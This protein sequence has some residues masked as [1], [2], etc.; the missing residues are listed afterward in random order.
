MPFMKS[1]GAASL[2]ATLLIGAAP[3]AAQAPSA[4][5]AGAARA[6]NPALA[7]LRRVEQTYNGIR[8]M[9]ATFEQR[10][11]VPLLGSNQRS[12]GRLFLRKPDRFAMVFTDPAGDRIVADGRH[13][14][15]YQPSS[16]PKQV[17]RTSIARGQRQVDFQR[18]F[19]TDAA[20]RYVP[21]LA[22]REMVDGRA[23]QVLSLVP[24]GSSPYKLI[25]AWVD[26]QDSLVRRW[27]I[28]EENGSVRRLDLRNV[29]LNAALPD[30][31]FRFTAPKGAQ[32]FD[33]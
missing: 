26:T 33:Q 29:R 30:S 20:R 14:W 16:D 9:E 17:I 32:I 8:S 13:F 4:R 27:E 25:R 28:T 18:Q 24:R 19:L 6:A 22:G 1:I 23:A 12:R 31:L 7:V 21:T 11:T 15:L 5:A 2:A 3:T 10:L